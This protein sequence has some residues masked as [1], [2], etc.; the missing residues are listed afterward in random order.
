[1]TMRPPHVV[2]YYWIAFEQ[3]NALDLWSH[4]PSL[5]ACQKA[6]R[7]IRNMIEDYF[8]N[9]QVD[10]IA[11]AIADMDTAVQVCIVWASYRAR[12]ET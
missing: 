1:M 9:G 2:V 6:E 12:E 3:E 10:E 4:S 5:C 7:R 8:I 11:A